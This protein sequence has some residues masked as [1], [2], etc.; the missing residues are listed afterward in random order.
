MQ[1]RRPAHGLQLFTH[2]LLEMSQC[3]GRR[4][5][6]K[7]KL[8][9]GGPFRY[10]EIQCKSVCKD[11]KSDLCMVCQRHEESYMKG[12]HKTWHG[13]MGGPIPPKA[14][15]LIGSNW[16]LAHRAKTAAKAEKKPTEKK[17]RAAAKTEKKPRATA[18]VSRKR[19]K[20]K[21]PSSSSGSSSGSSS[22]GSSSSRS[23]S[24]K[25]VSRRSSSSRRSMRRPSSSKHA[26]TMYRR[27]SAA[28]ASPERRKNRPLA[29]EER[30]TPILSN[31]KDPNPNTLA[32]IA[33]NLAGLPELD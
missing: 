13:I 19:T 24:S 26:N 32:N 25:R 14:V 12:D 5:G 17:P 8:P 11:P 23:S 4:C 22:S 20:A 15:G 16:N 3:I 31:K 2:A 10:K 27:A 21:T 18:A 30:G 6:E 1:T 28:S 33:A 7:V 9:E 29:V